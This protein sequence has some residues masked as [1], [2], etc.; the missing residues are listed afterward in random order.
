VNA[1][2]VKYNAIFAAPNNI[3]GILLVKLFRYQHG[4]VPAHGGGLAAA[5]RT[6]GPHQFNDPGF[7]GDRASGVNE[8][9]PVSEMWFLYFRR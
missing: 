7:A 4:P 1:E 3:Q 6:V 8:L 2:L 5:I 9:A